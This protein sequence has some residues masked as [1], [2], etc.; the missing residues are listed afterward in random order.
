MHGVGKG[1]TMLALML[2]PSGPQ[3]IPRDSTPVQVGGSLEVEE[4]QGPDL[5][6]LPV[7]PPADPADQETAEGTVC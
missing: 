6:G 5:R 1:P 2:P 3:N 4:P 7:D